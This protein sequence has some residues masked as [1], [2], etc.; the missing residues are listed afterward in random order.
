MLVA[1]L[2]GF[3]PLLPLIVEKRDYTY[4]LQ[5]EY[6]M[7]SFMSLFAILTTLVREL[8]KDMEDAEGDAAAGK[9]SLVIVLGEKATRSL[10]VVMLCCTLILFLAMALT[11]GDLLTPI[12]MSLFLAAPSVILI[13]KLIRSYRPSSYHKISTGMKF[14]MVSGLGYIVL[15]HYTCL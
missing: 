11:S 15:Y 13:Y 4:F 6:F 12:Y 5:P 14:I 10:S 9:L 7:I 8:V 1:L 3:L 2:C